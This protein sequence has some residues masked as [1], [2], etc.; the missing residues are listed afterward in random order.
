MRKKYAKDT[1]IVL[2]GGTIITVASNENK[3]TQNGVIVVCNGTIVYVEKKNGY[4]DLKS[5]GKTCN[6]KELKLS[7]NVILHQRL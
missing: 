3:I 2:T 7:K 6:A 4:Y 1:N 5:S